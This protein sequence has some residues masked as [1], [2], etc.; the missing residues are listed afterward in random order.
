M[1]SKRALSSRWASIFAIFFCHLSVT[2][3]FSLKRL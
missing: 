2:T 3:V 1:Q